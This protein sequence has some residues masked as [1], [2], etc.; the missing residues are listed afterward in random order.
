[1]YI[2]LPAA[3]PHPPARAF[4]IEIWAEAIAAFFKRARKADRPIEGLRA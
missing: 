4:P 1:M 3:R 2:D